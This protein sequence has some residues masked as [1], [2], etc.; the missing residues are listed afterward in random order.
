MNDYQ[1]TWYMQ[2]VSMHS[3]GAE[4]DMKRIDD[5]LSN[6]EMIQSRL[7]WFHLSSF[8]SHVGMISKLVSPISKDASANTRGNALKAAL[9][10]SATSEVLPRSARDNTEHFDERID[11]WVSANASDIME[12][13]LPDRDG[14]NFMRGDEK[15]VRRVLLKQ[16][17]VFMSENR[18]GSKFELE[19]KPLVQEVARIGHEATMWINTKSPYHFVYPEGGPNLKSGSM[20][21][22]GR[23]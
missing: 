10:V 22:Q 12:I 7:V 18:D 9:G 1:L 19:L 17:Y 4:F 20:L 23:T 3:Y 21:K 11:N 5:L 6:S 14:Y 16:E 2:E 8:L 15:R 13:V